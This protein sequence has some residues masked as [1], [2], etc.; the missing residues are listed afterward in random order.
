M[1]RK[2]FLDASKQVFENA[3]ALRHNMTPAEKNL[4]SYLRLKP[5][6]YKF[7]RQHA[8]SK[9]VADF[10]C[11]AVKLIIEIDGAIHNTKETKETDNARQSFLESEGIKFLRFSNDDI[12]TRFD[13]VQTV[14]ERHLRNQANI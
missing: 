13:Y 14:I 10:Y 5:L 9:Y 8:I 2:M 7:R 4:W 3:Y 6:G 11:H 1:Q 12:D